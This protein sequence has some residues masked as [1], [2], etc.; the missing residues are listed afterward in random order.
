MAS[1][2]K[3][4]RI[5]IRLTAEEKSLYLQAKAL[6][7]ESSISSF[8]KS[9]VNKRAKEIIE[10]NAKILASKRDKEIFFDAL[11]NAPEPNDALKKAAESHKQMISSES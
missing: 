5:D 9:I 3:T 2:A 8:I 11:V 7:H 6:V 1:T 4:D 10:E